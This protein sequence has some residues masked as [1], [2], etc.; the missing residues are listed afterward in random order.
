MKNKFLM[1]T[2]L[3][4]LGLSFVLLGQTSKDVSKVG[5]TA[6]TFLEI[7]AGAAANG[8][9]TAFVSRANDAS[10]LY[11]NVAG[12]ANLTENE[13][14]MIHTNWIAD[15]SFNYAALVL[16]LGNFG[17][18][19][20]SFTSLSMPDDK[21]RTVDQPDGTGEYFS[22]GDIAVG[23]SYAR[24]LTDRFSV[25]FTAK[26]IEESIWHMSSSAF[27]VDAG[28][29]FRTDLFGG[30]VIGASMSNFG[31]SMKLSGTDTRTY[32]SVDASQLGTN[33]QIPYV[34]DLDSWSLPLL[35]RIGVSTNILDNSDYRWTVALDALHPNDNYE[36]LNFGTEFAFQESL[37]LRGGYQ[38]YYLTDNQ[39]SE[40]GLTFG[41]GVSSKVLFS[42]DLVKFDY[43][44]RN[45]GR[46]NGVHSFSVDIKF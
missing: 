3:A 1:K 45:F 46:L 13:V 34:I 27:A 19:G 17:N 12:A 26:Y 25:G 38:S 7:G 32:S 11:W 21:V 35:F 39:D 30:M 33:D 10:A 15:I 22:A 8:M 4:F 5:T 16:A 18:L 41:I 20:F 24:K 43:A 2:I 44:Y 29:I 31:T 36:S 6:A 23:I 14:T 28:T 37:F 40:G 42:T 9:G